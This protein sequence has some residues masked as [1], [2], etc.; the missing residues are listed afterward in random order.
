[1]QKNFKFTVPQN[2]EQVRLDKFLSKQLPNTSREKIKK[3][4]KTKNVS[5]NNKIVEKISTQINNNDTV[6]I[7]LIEDEDPTHLIPEK[8]ELNILFED[9]DLIVI[10]KPAGLV[11][12][13]GAGNKSGT[14][15]NALL[16][17]TANLSQEKTARPGIVHRLDKD[18]S[19]ILVVAKNDQTHLKLT[20]LFSK[21]D[22]NREYIA[23]CFGKFEKK[24][25][26]IEGNITRSRFN[27][28]KMALT[29]TEKGKPSKTE[30][31]VIKYYKSANVS[32]VKFKLSTGRTHQ[33]RLHASS[34]AHPVVGDKT[35]GNQ[36]T[37]IKNIKDKDLKELIKSARRQMLHAHLLGFTHPTTKKYVE[38]KT[39]PE[40]DMKNLIEYL[41]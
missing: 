19:G 41:K 33:I 29:N 10:N 13:P 6:K 4:I 40:E 21:H 22:I 18:T 17:H 1:M 39:E 5:V 9:K 30:Y 34:I 2:I 38:F 31:V 12:H 20:K 25:G 14:L 26:I 7:T 15:A 11:V 23:L 35:Y 16:Y 27:R 24:T 36:N 32:L 28:K 8:I 37:H 3:M